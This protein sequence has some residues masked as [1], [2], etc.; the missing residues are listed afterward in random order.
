MSGWIPI[1][2]PIILPPE[3]GEVFWIEDGDWYKI[4]PKPHDFPWPEQECF[5]AF[6]SGISRAVQ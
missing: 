5:Y 2:E 6:C 1:T 3:G 4:I